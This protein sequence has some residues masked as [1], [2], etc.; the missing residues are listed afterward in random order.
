MSKAKLNSRIGLIQ[1]SMTIGISAKAKE[2][3]ANG[4]NVINFSA[5]EPDFDTPDNIKMAAIKSL[6]EGFTKYTAAGGIN[7]LRD[8]VAK[9]EKVKNNL[10]Y[11]RENV[12]I[13]VGAKHALF[14]IAAVMLEPPDEVIIIS[15][16]WVTY[17]AIVSYVGATPIIIDTKQ[18]NGFVPTVEDI[19][20]KITE[21][22]KMIWINNPTNPTGATYTQQQL[23]DIAQL[24]QRHDLW[25]VSDEIY[26]DI[27]F[28]GYKPVSIA[29]LSDYAYERTLVVNGVSKTYSMTGWRIGYTCGD[30][31][32]IAAMIKLLSQSTSNPTS[33]A[34][35]AA[36]EALEG[37]QDSVERMRLEFE[38][39]RDYIVGA[40]NGMEGISCYKPKGAFYVFP[41]IS[42]FFGKS[43][44]GKKIENSMDF[45]TLLLE[46]AHVATVPGI[47]FGDDRFMRVSFATSL[48]DIE[49]GM[50]R[51]KAFIEK[52]Q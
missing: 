12:C 24:A 21:N 36:L 34:Q 18:E 35:T 38:K 25:I 32:I 10:E 26:E 49:E 17:E 11:K 19:E 48:E 37:P 15:P 52:I 1:P 20:A 51:L 22:T 2:L 33:I 46:H 23:E 45:C 30:K 31:D 27:V 6:A 42:S 50:A 8:A 40:L 44:E 9:K 7:E 5:G 16:Y 13:S 29:T 4:V 3:K 39:R 41:N 14:N 43:Y 28:D 47:A